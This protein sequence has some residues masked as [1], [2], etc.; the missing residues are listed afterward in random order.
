MFTQ[1]RHVEA[2]KLW[3]VRPSQG[4]PRPVC[5][6]FGTVRRKSGQILPSLDKSYPDLALTI[7][8]GP[9]TGLAQYSNIQHVE[10]KL[11]QVRSGHRQVSSS[12]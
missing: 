10:D 2:G 5:G 9:Q 6:T 12:P 4:L 8:N 7:P 3:Q 1:V 11:E